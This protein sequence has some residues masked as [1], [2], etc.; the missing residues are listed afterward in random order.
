MN[1]I[2][3]NKKAQLDFPIL[4]FVV[5]VL[6]LI[7]FGPIMLKT[8]H[9]I[10]N[11][12][13]PAFGNVTN[14]GA[15]AQAN[16]NAAMNPLIGFWDEIMIAAF[17]FSVILLFISSFLIDTHPLWVILYIFLAMMLVLFIPN[18]MQGAD[19][20]YSNSQFGVEVSELSFMDNLRLNFAS[21]VMGLIILTGA[22]IYGKVSFFPSSGGS[23]R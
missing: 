11:G 10:Q 2:K 12:L 16:F 5:V 21:I 8:F 23:G 3:T 1:F 9:S 14:G 15:T 20:I 4:G 18:M 22:I 6:A 7:M 17:A 13:S 19:T